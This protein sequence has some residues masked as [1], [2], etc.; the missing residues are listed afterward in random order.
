MNPLPA[1]LGASALSAAVAAAVTVSLVDS[2]SPRETGER[3][4]AVPERPGTPAAAEEE[5]TAEELATIAAAEADMRIA[6]LE[7][8]IE[9]LER[10]LASQRTALITPGPAEEATSID[11]SDPLARQ[12]VLDVMAAEEERE[13]QE[14]EARREAQQLEQINRQADRIAE[15][16]G[17]AEQQRSELVEVLLAVDDQRDAAREQMR[18]GGFEGARET[19][20]AIE[21]YKD[22]ELVRRFG[23]EVAKQIDEAE[24]NRRGGGRGGRGGF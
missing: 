3:G 24:D 9:E 14:R 15:R 21:E 17:L 6:A 8:R 5:R 16:V 23:E 7:Q 22:A 20:R 18:E 2:S 13:R 19:F 11:P 12:L 10:R 1:L 4:A